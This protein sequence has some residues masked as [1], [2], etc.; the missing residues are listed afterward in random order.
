M[1]VFF[2][3]TEM[4]GYFASSI[5]HLA[6]V[7]DTI[8]IIRW[9]V[10]KEA[11]FIFSFP[12]NVKVFERSDYN[13]NSIIDLVNSVN[14][15]IIIS[16]G[17]M[18]KS[19]LK[20]CKQF[21]GKIPVVMGMDNQWRGTLKQHIMSLIAPLTLHKCYSHTWVPGAPQKKYALKLGFNKENVFEGYYSADT[22]LF[23]K[24]AY[25]RINSEKY[26][27][28]FIYIGRYVKVKGLDLLFKAFCELC[29]ENSYEWELICAGTGEMFD[30]KPI[31]P[32]IKHLG[33][34][35]PNQLKDVIK[36]AGVF[37]LPSKFEPWGVV[38]HEMATAGFP[39]IVSDETGA[40]SSFLKNSKNGY[41]FKNSDYKSLKYAMK[42][43]MLKSDK[44]L[45]NMAKISHQLGTN[46]SPKKWS[47][48]L[49][50]IVESFKQN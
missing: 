9:P 39:M 11:P 15:D 49:F 13:T 32:K 35:Q 34:V 21:K 5:K 41:T 40:V 37:I 23:E 42:K 6:S 19:Y 36:E 16:S 43:M 45:K 24:S 27:R 3:Y 29:N 1:K 46:H 18:D 38:V 14:P 47:Q 28:K 30:K 50:K 17:W 25:D 2:L 44:E 7:T 12:N 48:L 33:F 8:Y 26:P 22:K 31:H 10:N 20:V 4:A